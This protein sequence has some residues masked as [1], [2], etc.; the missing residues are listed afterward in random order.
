MLPLVDFAM[1]YFIVSNLDPLLLGDELLPHFGISKNQKESVQPQ[2][3]T[4]VLSM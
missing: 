3:F 4:D 2:D 1:L